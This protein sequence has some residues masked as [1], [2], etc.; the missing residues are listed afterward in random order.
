MSKA[1]LKSRY[2]IVKIHFHLVHQAN[3]FVLESCQV[4]Q[5]WFPFHESLLIISSH[6]LVFHMCRDGFEDYFLHHFPRDWGEADQPVPPSSWF[7]RN[8]LMLLLVLETCLQQNK[9]E[10][11]LLLSITIKTLNQARVCV[12]LAKW[13]IHYVLITASS[14]H[15]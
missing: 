11:N 3:H 10:S 6:L 15:M 12:F 2:T 13:H 14:F 7:F 4:G 9:T 8:H 5:M 1:L